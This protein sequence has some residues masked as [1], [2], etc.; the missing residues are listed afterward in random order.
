MTTQVLKYLDI[1]IQIKYCA[2]AYTVTFYFYVY[3]TTYCVYI[4][5]AMME[6]CVSCFENLN[7]PYIRTVF[8]PFLEF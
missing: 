6:K 5:S 3:P 2:S 1:G 7:M 8:L 4:Y